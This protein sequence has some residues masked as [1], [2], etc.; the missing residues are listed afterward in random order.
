[1]IKKLTVVALIAM[2]D[3]FA[4]AALPASADHYDDNVGHYNFHNPRSVQHFWRDQ[5][6]ERSH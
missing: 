3:V 2:L 4:F 6:E 5:G 1:M